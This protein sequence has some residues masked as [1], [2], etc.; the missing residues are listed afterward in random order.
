MPLSPKRVMH[1]KVQRGSMKGNAKGGTRLNHG[2][3]GIQALEAAWITNRQIEAA[4]IAMTRHMINRKLDRKGQVWI[5]VFP[6]KPISKKP[7]EVRMGKGKGAPESWAAVIKPGMILFEIDGVDLKV[8]H[9]ALE[10]A[11]DKLP[12]ITKIAYKPTQD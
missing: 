5:R 7:A 4:R 2:Q 11:A 8:A 9:R 12:V 6:D 3:W 10:L 1:R